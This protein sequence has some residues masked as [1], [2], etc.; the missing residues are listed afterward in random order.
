MSVAG[1]DVILL[2]RP[3]GDRERECRLPVAD[4]GPAD[5]TCAAGGGLTKTD[6]M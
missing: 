4:R 6:Q 1:G 5:P 3:A 2:C